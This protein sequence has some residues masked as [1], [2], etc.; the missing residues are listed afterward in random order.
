MGL[1]SLMNSFAASAHGRRL[2]LLEFATFFKAE[3]QQQKKFQRGSA[4]AENE[5]TLRLWLRACL[6]GEWGPQIS[7]VTRLGGV[8]R[9][10]I[11]LI[12]VRLHDRWV[13]WSARPG[14]PLSG[15]QILPCKRFKV[16]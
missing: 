16:G 8:T 7:E 4:T 15:G 12:R 2:C 14:N 13:A 3:K 1:I 6:R 9:L 5:S 11:E 10:S